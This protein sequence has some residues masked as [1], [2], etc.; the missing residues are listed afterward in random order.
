MTWH[1]SKRD[2]LYS[3]ADNARD[4]L[5]VLGAPSI[6]PLEVGEGS[7]F[8]VAAY[9]S[10]EDADKVAPKKGEFLDGMGQYMTALP[11]P[12][13]SEVTWEMES[14]DHHLETFVLKRF[15]IS[16]TA[17]GFQIDR[18]GKL[19]HRFIRSFS[20]FICSFHRSSQPSK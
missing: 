7:T 8:T 2:E 10:K 15:T 19:I 14:S 13:E 5:K 11:E 17:F 12:Y 20:Q 6:F 9:I 16:A 4:R 18:C 3:H 1:P